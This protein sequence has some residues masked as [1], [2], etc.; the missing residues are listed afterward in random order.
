[1]FK[2]NICKTTYYIRLKNKILNYITGTWKPNNLPNIPIIFHEFND[3]Y[4][5]SHSTHFRN[6]FFFCQ[7]LLSK[8]KTTKKTFQMPPRPPPYRLKTDPQSSQSSSSSSS[9]SAT[10]TSNEYY[11]ESFKSNKLLDNKSDDN[12]SYLWN[13]LMV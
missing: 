8:W 11:F 10:T 4:S 9:A 5:F 2:A 1:M 7:K 13:K 6:S 3:F 12:L